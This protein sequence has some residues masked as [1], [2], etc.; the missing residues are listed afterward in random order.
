MSTIERMP[1]SVE[2][3]DNV[4]ADV[5]NVYAKIAAKAYAYF[6]D[7]GCI[8][9]H[10]IDDWL[11]A[12]RELISKPAVRLHRENSHFIVN[13]DLPGIHPGDLNIKVSSQQM[14]VISVP[15]DGRQIFCIVRFPEPVDP[16]AVEATFHDGELRISAPVAPETAVRSLG[17]VA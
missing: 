17:T 8:N 15:F 3:V 9:G 7:S 5:Q 10:D 12:E 6:L 11:R 1:V 16:A 14:L 13:V 2:C 4:C